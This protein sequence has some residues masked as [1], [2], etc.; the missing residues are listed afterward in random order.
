MYVVCVPEDAQNDSEETSLAAWKA[1]PGMSPLLLQLAHL[2]QDLVHVELV[3]AGVE[4]LE[5]DDALLVNHEHRAVG[6][7]ALLVVDSVELRDLALGVEV[8]QN[9]VGYVAKRR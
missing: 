4:A 8:R 2:G 9:R 1:Y 7:A 6:R 3:H 5:P